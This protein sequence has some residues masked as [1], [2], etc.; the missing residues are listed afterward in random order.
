MLS[1]KD[2]LQVKSL[3]IAAVIN[4]VILVIGIVFITVSYTVPATCDYLMG[5]MQLLAG[6]VF[7]PGYI[8][9]FATVWQDLDYD[10]HR[11]II[12]TYSAI[13]SGVI[14]WQIQFYNMV[15]KYP[16]I[17]TYIMNA[18]NGMYLILIFMIFLGLSVSYIVKPR[19]NLI[20][21]ENTPPGYFGRY[22]FSFIL[23]FVCCYAHSV[24]QREDVQSISGTQI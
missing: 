14:L 6:T 8:V 24:S 5:A 15:I 18:F 21:R 10:R 13:F 23:R 20:D 19:L 22:S 16:T 7:L 17:L 11:I 2:I 3:Q 4:F 12:P 9:T 1:W